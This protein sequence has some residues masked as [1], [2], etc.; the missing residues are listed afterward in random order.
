MGSRVVLAIVLAA[1]SV[2]VLEMS[3]SN[4]LIMLCITITLSRGFGQSALSVVSL[5]LVGKWFGRGLNY[6]MGIYSLLVGI[7]FIAAFPSVGSAVLAYGWRTAW[8]SVGL[9]LLLLA[10]LM[11]IV[12]SNVPEDRGLQFDEQ[13]P[14]NAAVGADLTPPKRCGALRFGFSRYPAPCSD[15]CT[16]AFPSS[17]NR[18][19]SNVVS[20]HRYT[21]QCSLSVH[22]SAWWQISAADGWPHAGRYS[23]LWAWVWPS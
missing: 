10:P 11:W 9:A 14:G 15:S 6:A 2:T 8:S 22:C 3:V 5:A 1:L 23:V 20:M 13:D 4:G 21:T 16:L 18:F 12:V 17:I 7:G 19:S